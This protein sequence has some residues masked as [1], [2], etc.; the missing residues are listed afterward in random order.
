MHVAW[1]ASR[2]AVSLMYTWSCLCC[3][4]ALFALRTLSVLMWSSLFSVFLS[5]C[6]TSVLLLFLSLFLVLL[7]VCAFFLFYS[8][9]VP[10]LLC[11]SFSCSCLCYPCLFWP[12]G[13][14]NCRRSLVC[15]E[16]LFFFIIK[17][18]MSY[19]LAYV[20]ARPGRWVSLIEVSVIGCAL[21]FVF[22]FSG[23][24]FVASLLLGRFLFSRFLLF[25][26]LSL[27]FLSLSLAASASV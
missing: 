2:A 6:P 11:G 7:T 15:C 9:S 18:Y 4:R 14:S 10:R 17:D 22:S 8:S 19:A 21:L 13:G 5:F 12:F 16:L 1:F 20:D 27:S 24:M 3:T 26:S 23:P 25:S